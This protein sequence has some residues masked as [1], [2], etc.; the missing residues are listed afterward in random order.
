M[1]NGAVPGLRAVVVVVCGG[2]AGGTWTRFPAQRTCDVLP[3][4]KR[5]GAGESQLVVRSVTATEQEIAGPQ[6]C[7][8]SCIVWAHDRQHDGL[9]PAGDETEVGEARARLPTRAWPP[10]LETVG[11]PAS[12]PV[13][14][15]APDNLKGRDN[16][17]CIPRRRTRSMS[18]E[19][20]SPWGLLPR[21]P[22]PR[23]AAFRRGGFGDARAA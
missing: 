10:S 4:G 23:G 8:L 2:K 14:P 15:S 22:L 1:P 18:S 11:H 20:N 17:D 12:G 21:C 6:Q 7:G 13:L 3:S 19:D 16:P 9:A 5:A